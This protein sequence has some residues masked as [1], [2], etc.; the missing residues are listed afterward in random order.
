VD[1]REI[2]SQLYTAGGAVQ[3]GVFPIN[4]DGPTKPSRVIITPACNGGSS[5]IMYSLA[6]Y[7]RYLYEACETPVAVLIYD[8]HRSGR[9]RPLFRLTGAFSG[10]HQL[11]LGP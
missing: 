3:I 1:D 6:I 2:F 9:V 5:S 10:A 11:V 7:S 4:S 8:K